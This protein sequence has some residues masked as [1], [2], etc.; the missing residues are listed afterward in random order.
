M[1]VGMKGEPCEGPAGPSQSSQVYWPRRDDPMIEGGTLLRIHHLSC[2]PMRPFAFVLSGTATLHSRAHLV[3]HCLLVKTDDR[4]VLVDTGFGTADLTRPA[5]AAWPYTRGTPGYFTAATPTSGAARSTPTTQ[6]VRAHAGSNRWRDASFPT[7]RGCG[8]CSAIVGT[9]CTCSAP[10]TRWSWPDKRTRRKQ[11]MARTLHRL[12][13]WRPAGWSPLC[14]FRTGLALQ[15]PAARKDMPCR[16][17]PMWW[18][19]E[20]G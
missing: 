7:R 11:A 9:R 12:L 15:P 10:T 20:R 16:P 17:A 6:W 18:S 13:L 14:G 19:S 8:P 3:V 4:R 1:H 2:T 5:T